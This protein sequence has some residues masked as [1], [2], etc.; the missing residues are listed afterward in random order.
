[1]RVARYEGCRMNE[2]DTHALLSAYLDDELAAADRARVE[3]ALA[4]DAS[5][6]AELESL[7]SVDALF[8]PDAA[9]VAA[10]PELAKR[11]R[12]A[13]RHEQ[14]SAQPRDTESP[15]ARWRF[16]APLAAA[17]GVLVAFGLAWQFSG[18]PRDTL[19]LADAPV[20]DSP[21][22]ERAD[23]MGQAVTMLQAPGS[24]PPPA[25]PPAADALE[26]VGEGAALMSR[27][28]EMAMRSASPML[29]AATSADA[30]DSAS[31]LVRM[32]GE[33]R[34]HLEDGRWTPQGYA[35]EA[36]PPLPRDDARWLS[37]TAEA[38]MLA[39]RTW[40]EPVLVLIDGGWFEVEAMPG[41]IGAGPLE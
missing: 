8:R 17:A 25:A 40:E 31:P 28:E 9:P 27:P 33:M 18:E 20:A 12:A 7:R 26:M 37:L 1:M 13:L 41:S 10:P 24:P 35:G 30:D 14:D 39:L 22:L 19:Y 23:E 16:A 36:A 29:E 15:R 34:Y 11:V 21:V 38:P 2:P 32:V 6:R 5:L 4:A 3:E